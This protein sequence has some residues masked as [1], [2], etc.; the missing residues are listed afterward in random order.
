MHLQPQTSKM[1][2]EVSDLKCIFLQN[3]YSLSFFFKGVPS[4]LGQH[5]LFV[6]D[7]GNSTKLHFR[8]TLFDGL[9]Q[10][11]T[12]I[13]T[14]TLS[15]YGLSCQWVSIDA[16]RCSQFLVDA[17]RCPYVYVGVSRCRQGVSKCSNVSIVVYRCIQLLIGVLRC[18]QDFLR[19]K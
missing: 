12:D 1:I 2:R 3:D 10:S 9:R 5:N 7:Y 11:T 8:I 19:G 16:R 14:Y 4:V 13:L 6:R 17:R 18:S 15:S